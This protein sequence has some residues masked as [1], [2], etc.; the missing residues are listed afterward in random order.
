MLPDELKTNIYG[1]AAVYYYNTYHEELLLEAY[2][3]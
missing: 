2:L 3:A 1:V